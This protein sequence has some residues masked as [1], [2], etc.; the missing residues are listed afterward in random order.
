[1]KKANTDDVKWKR[2]NVY[3]YL[4]VYKEDILRSEA[5]SWIQQTDL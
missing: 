1:M 4:Y 3:H 2:V 5:Y